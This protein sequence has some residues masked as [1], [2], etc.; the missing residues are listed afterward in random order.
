MVVP[1][2][3]AALRQDLK[4]L[5]IEVC[6][7]DGITP[8]DIGDEERLIRGGGSFDLGSLDALEIAAAIDYRYQVKIQDLSSAKTIFRSVASLADH[9]AQSRGWKL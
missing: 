4:L 8:A 7:L 3:I 1:E 2:N 6:Q 5:I 9:I